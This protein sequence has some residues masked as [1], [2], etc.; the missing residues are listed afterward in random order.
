MAQLGTTY[1]QVVNLVLRRLREAVMTDFASPTSNQQMVMD[2]VNTVKHEIEAA[3]FWDSM[4]D[5]YELTVT[6]GLGASYEFTGVNGGSRVIDAWNEASHAPVLKGS[7]LQFNQRFM[8][9]MT[10]ESGMVSEYVENSVGATYLLKV[11]VW[12]V[13]ASTQIINF[14][15]FVAQA[16]LSATTDVPKIPPHVLVEGTL[17][18]LLQERGDDSA[19]AQLQRYQR[20]LADAVA[21]DASRHPE[22]TDWTPV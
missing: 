14:N 21:A 17:G 6:P 1:L 15:I 9:G 3:W 7:Y 4:R 20:V 12:P 19:T 18:Y 8:D 13:P 11:D 10:P 16:D 5:T 2:M 22:E